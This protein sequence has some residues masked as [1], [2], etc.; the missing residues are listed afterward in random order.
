M[1][2]SKASTAA[3]RGRTENPSNRPM[4]AHAW[5]WVPS[6]AWGGGKDFGGPFPPPHARA[7][8]EGGAVARMGRWEG[9]RRWCVSPGM[10]GAGV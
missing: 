9:F 5:K 3:G 6:R 4:P 1:V 8:M 10:D 2:R 7:R